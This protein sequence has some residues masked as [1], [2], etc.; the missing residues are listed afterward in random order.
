MPKRSKNKHLYTPEQQ[1]EYLESFKAGVME[2]AMQGCVWWVMD[3]DEFRPGEELPVKA[4][5]G[6][7]ATGGAHA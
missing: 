2:P 7:Q 6:L 5:V 1:A 3:E 4:N